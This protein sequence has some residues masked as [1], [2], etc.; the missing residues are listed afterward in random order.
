MT[1]P[2]IAAD[3][4]EPEELDQIE[5]AFDGIWAA[6]VANDPTRNPAKDEELKYVISQKLFALVKTGV[7]DPEL[8][9]KLLCS[10]T[11]LN[12]MSNGSG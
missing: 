8:L 1:L 7:R 2:H 9:T 3:G 6:V 4:F 12:S 10:T 5:K 11:P